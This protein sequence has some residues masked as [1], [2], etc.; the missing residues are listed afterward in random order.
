M[1]FIKYT[2]L[3]SILAAVSAAPALEERTL[4][5]SK[6]VYITAGGEGSKASTPFLGKYFSASGKSIWLGKFPSF[7]NNDG[8]IPTAR[9]E[10]LKV[11]FKISNY[12][13][14]DTTTP[15]GQRVFVAPD[16][17]LSYTKPTSTS[18]PSGSVT[19]TFKV[20]GSWLTA[21]DTDFLACP[22]DSGNKG[23]WKVFSDV[24]GRVKDSA[25]PSKKKSDC[26]T[27]KAM[28]VTHDVSFYD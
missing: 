15:N 21:S 27:F 16:G 26:T 12:V 23:P 24:N 22:T 17:S 3:F 8:D 11:A 25:V 4:S 13:M 20:D 9:P 10:D 19:N 1:I 28:L 18:V 2:A 6:S 5:A 14:L 7:E